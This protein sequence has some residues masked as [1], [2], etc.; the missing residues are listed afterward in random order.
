M[1]EKRE[2]ILE[3]A[4]VLF[5]EKGYVN[6]P[7]REIID[8][9]GYGTGT[10]YKYFNNKEEVLKVLLQD[11]LDQ[12]ISAVREFFNREKDLYVRFI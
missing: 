2:K 9:S 11:F 4:Q 7:V 5:A 1:M 10:F 6:T 3:S 12:I 8:L